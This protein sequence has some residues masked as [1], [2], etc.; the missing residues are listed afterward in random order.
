MS[1]ST[2]KT[3]EVFRDVRVDDNQK[4]ASL[5]DV[6][7]IVCECNTRYAA[8]IIRRLDVN[9]YNKCQYIRING[10]GHK[11]P[12]G[13]DDTIK[14]VAIYAISQSRM[15][16]EKK[17][18]WLR[19]LG[20]QGVVMKSY[21]EPDI[22]RVLVAALQ[23]FKPETHY[24]ILNYR[25]DLYLHGANIAI[26]CDEHGHS[27][28]NQKDEIER[29]VSITNVLSC[30]WV[31]FNPHATGFNIGDVMAQVLSLLL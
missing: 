21:I 19:I 6:I 10:K 24:P 2:L 8:L 5:I 12:V 25:L 26:E 30:K 11:T 1:L 14:D 22:L 29:V 27:D 16:T 31:R 15:S 3:N 13:D 17:E 4:Q 20:V 7:K 9:L 28:Y 23:R 18:A